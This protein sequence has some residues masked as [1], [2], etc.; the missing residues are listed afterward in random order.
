VEHQV[1]VCFISLKLIRS[2]LGL[3]QKLTFTETACL[4]DIAIFICSNEDGIFLN[5]VTPSYTFGFGNNATVGT[6][7]TNRIGTSSVMAKI[8]ARN[9]TFVKA[10][11]T[12][13]GLG[14]DPFVIGCNKHSITWVPLQGMCIKYV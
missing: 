10:T 7:Y 3:L 8:I 2:I 14:F 12:I 11:I 5:F 6:N 1:G 4:G 13:T 9:S